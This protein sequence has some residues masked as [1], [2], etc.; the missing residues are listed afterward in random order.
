MKPLCCVTSSSTCSRLT[1][2]FKI[3]ASVWL[4]DPKEKRPSDGH[5][6]WHLA[7]SGFFPQFKS[8]NAL[9]TNDTKT[10]DLWPRHQWSCVAYD[11]VCCIWRRS[12]RL[13]TDDAQHD[14]S[15][16]R[17][18]RE[19]HHTDGLSVSPKRLE[20]FKL[21]TAQDPEMQLLTSQ[22]QKG[23]PSSRKE[24][25]SPLIPYHESRSELIE[26]NG[27][28]FRGERLVVPPS[29]RT[30]MLKE[31]HRSHIGMNG[32]LRRAR[33]LLF[34]PRINAEVKDLVSKC[35][36]WQS[37]QPEQYRE[38][39]QP[40]EMPSRT[41]PVISK[42]KN[43]NGSPPQ[44]SSP[45]AKC[46]LQD[47]EFLMSWLQTTGHNLAHQNSRNSPRRGNLNTRLQVRTIPSQTERQRTPSKSAKI[48]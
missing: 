42:Y 48:C 2:R 20:K 39:L 16:V 36:I 40:H 7:S 12:Y 6:N 30:D 38:D 28:V 9:G 43:S 32:C 14:S 18:L 8:H 4:S 37:F 10:G 21:R 1:L 23:W 11:V 31:I 19:V 35:S 24:C 27:L 29:L 44:L 45:L 22:I 5:G 41:G 17:A 34:W 46:S 13:T 26:E 15:E 47:M 25:P 33:E 3:R